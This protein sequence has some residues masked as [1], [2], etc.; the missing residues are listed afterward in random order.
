MRFEQSGAGYPPQGVGSPDPFAQHEI[1]LI[2]V[3]L[4]VG[5]IGWLLLATPI[6][7]V[8]TGVNAGSKIAE[9]DRA[10]VINQDKLIEYQKQTQAPFR[11]DNRKSIGGWLIRDNA[12]VEMLLLPCGILMTINTIYLLVASIR[13]EKHK[14]A[15]RVAGS[16]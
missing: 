11:P 15:K 8:A 1:K 6:V 16:N 13:N 7:R 14:T 12:Y 9:L 4:N 10:G 5:M 2:L 3:I